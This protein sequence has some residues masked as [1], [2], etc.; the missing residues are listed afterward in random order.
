[1]PRQQPKVGQPAYDQCP[2]T[3]RDRYI[4][5]LQNL[6]LVC[7]DSVDI[8]RRYNLM[9]AGPVPREV[10][11]PLE[12]VIVAQLDTVKTPAVRWNYR[13]ARQIRRFSIWLELAW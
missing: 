1:M 7:P 6:L 4:R 3:Q 12:R 11:T 8:R 9:L 5:Q 2:M 13:L 10:H